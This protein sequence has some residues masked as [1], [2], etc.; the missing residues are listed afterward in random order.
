[1]KNVRKRLTAAVMLSLIAIYSL[2]GCSSGKMSVSEVEDTLEQY[3]QDVYAPKS[4][5]QFKDAKEDSDKLFTEG[6][7]NRF[8]VAYADDLSEE[9][10]QR[11]C[12]TYI[13]H[14]EA[15]YQSDGIERYVITAYLY[16]MKGATPIVKEFTFY[17]N[18]DGK[19]YD[20]S[21]EDPE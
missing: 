10:K 14:G 12:E 2:S 7:K 3:M 16:E 11:I 21:I 15:K 8:F 9:D 19:V 5:K 17:I 6:A 13:K 4:M 20:F 18:N 1:M